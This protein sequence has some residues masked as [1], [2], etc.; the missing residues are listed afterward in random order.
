MNKVKNF[1]ARKSSSS[2]LLFYLLQ[3]EFC[4]GMEGICSMQG[5]NSDI[6]RYYYLGTE[7]GTTLHPPERGQIAP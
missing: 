2:N 7:L 5:K 6:Q 3:R 4:D 1:V